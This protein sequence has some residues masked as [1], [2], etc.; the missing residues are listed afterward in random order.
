MTAGQPVY[1]RRKGPP[2]GARAKASFGWTTGRGKSLDTEHQ[3][4]SAHGSSGGTAGA[5]IRNDSTS[6]TFTARRYGWIMDVYLIPEYR[7]RGL[8]RQLTGQAM[9]WL[10]EKG[11]VTVRLTASDEAKKAGLYEQ[12]GLTPSNEMRSRFEEDA[13]SATRT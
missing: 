12:L 4:I 13:P 3:F 9:Q 1:S 2:E 11:I 5:L 8:A 6:F 7:R 10:R